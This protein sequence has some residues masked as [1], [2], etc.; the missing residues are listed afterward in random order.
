M[1]EK[2]ILKVVN[3]D[4]GE[5]HIKMRRDAQLGTLH[6]AYCQKLNV[7]RD[8]VIFIGAD[9]EPLDDGETPEQ[10]HMEDD[11]VIDAVID[12][13]LLHGPLREAEGRDITG[14]R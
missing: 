12:L 5:V 9:G 13:A 7:N 14:T 11:E 3:A 2:I 8:N 1:A 6:R 4:G 10:H